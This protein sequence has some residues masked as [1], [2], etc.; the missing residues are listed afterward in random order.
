MKAKD[1]IILNVGKS[2]IS[3]IKVK[4]KCAPTHLFNIKPGIIAITTRQQKKK[5][6]NHK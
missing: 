6:R 2:I 5:K 3:K 1:I 4:M